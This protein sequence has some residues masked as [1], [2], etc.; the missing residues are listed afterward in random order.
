MTDAGP[1]PARPPG[2]LR[3]VEIGFVSDVVCPWCVVG[4]KQLE[5]ALGQMAV[6]ARLTWHPFELNPQ[7]PPEGQNLRQHL[8]EK[9][10]ITEQ[11]SHQ[12]RAHLTRIGAELGFDFNLSD[13]MR[14]VN[15]FRAH[16]LLDWAAL[17][18]RQ[19]PLMLELFADHFSR[20]RDVSDDAVLTAA[21]ARAGL[22]PAAARLALESGA[23]AAPV[24]ARQRFWIERGIR[25]VPSIVFANRYLTTGAQGTEAFAHALQRCLIETAT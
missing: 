10:G 18:G 5:R 12:A 17:H 2:D 4:F 25:S 8:I 22:D 16:Q 7:M 13:D 15:T 14:M 20:G 21:A 3:V 9:N 1:V 11:Q 23:H 6:R 24:R 19:H